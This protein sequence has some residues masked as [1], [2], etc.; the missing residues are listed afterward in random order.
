VERADVERWVQAYEGAWASNDPEE[1][2]ALFTDDA[3][4]YTAPER[5][6]WTG[7]D[8]IVREWLG[9][10]DEPG[11]YTFRS[12]VLGIDGDLAFVRGWT[13]YTKEG[14]DYSNLW[15][16]RLADD[17]RASEF[18]EWWMEQEAPAGGTP[19]DSA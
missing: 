12:E 6:P 8:T 13:T 2:G 9:R 19:S 10:K 15:V 1:I 16:I 3:R 17:G 18:I 5:E 7:R 11:E 14:Q 4:Y